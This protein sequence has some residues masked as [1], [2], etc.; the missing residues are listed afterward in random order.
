MQANLVHLT[1]G[2]LLIE[3]SILLTLFPTYQ[4]HIHQDRSMPIT[5]NQKDKISFPRIQ[6]DIQ[7][8][9]PK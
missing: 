1:Q 6:I 4:K 9:T 2:A 7:L 5:V 3:V 8:V